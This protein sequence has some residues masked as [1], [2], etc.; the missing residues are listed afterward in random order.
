MED[1]SLLV[2]K[3]RSH[4]AEGNNGRK[5]TICHVSSSSSNISLSLTLI[6]TVERV[7]LSGSVTLHTP[8]MTETLI[9]RLLYVLFF[10]M[11][12]CLELSLRTYEQLLTIVFSII[13]NCIVGI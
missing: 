13:D 4:D 3:T 2:I 1:V 8:T 6:C 11:E 9:N 7:W 10:F 12:V 5:Q